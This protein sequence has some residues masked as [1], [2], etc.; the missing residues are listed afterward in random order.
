MAGPVSIMRPATLAAAAG[1]RRRP[2]GPSRL[3]P[4]PWVVALSDI[5]AGPFLFQQ[6][7]GGRTFRKAWYAAIPP[8]ALRPGRKR[9]NRPG[10]GHAGRDR[11]EGTRRFRPGKSRLAE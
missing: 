3:E 11:G 9:P 5:A 7:V 10:L 4:L 6:D 2:T 1:M 8:R